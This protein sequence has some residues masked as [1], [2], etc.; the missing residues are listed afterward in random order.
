MFIQTEE[1]PNPATVK[2]LPGQEVLSSGTVDFSSVSEAGH[3]PLAKR[4]FTIVGVNRVF[5]AK[6]FV[7][8][9]TKKGEE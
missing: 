2:F 3:S 9:N 5:L 6:D 1:T 4:L 7:P 8:G